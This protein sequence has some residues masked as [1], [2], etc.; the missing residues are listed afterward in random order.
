MK[1]RHI[2][3]L[4]YHL[5][6]RYCV[7]IE[8]KACDFAPGFIRLD[9]ILCHLDDRLTIDLLLVKSKSGIFTI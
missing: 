4:F 9:D 8:F 3:L 2:N 1:Y 5:K 7:V 6:L